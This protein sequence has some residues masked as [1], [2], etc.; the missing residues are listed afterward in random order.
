MT[1][2]CWVDMVGVINLRSRPDR[3]REMQG[4][5]D[6]I[7]LGN[8]SRVLFIDGIVA[9]DPAPFR[10]VGERGV[11]LSHLSILR[12]AAAAE[13]SV[14]ILEDDADFTPAAMKWNPSSGWDIAYGGYSAT[15]P[16]FL[17]IS[18]I[19]GAHC[20]G[21]SIR[22]AGALVPYLERLLTIESPPPI[23]GAYVWFRREFP[24]FATVFAEPVIADQRPS[25][26]DIAGS[27]PFDRIVILRPLLGIARSI[28][29]ML[30][31]RR[32]A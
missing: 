9:D 5:L 18:D 14:L 4:E 15:D 6:R 27:G 25:R 31:R 24:E 29:R 17:A 10:L 19:V 1:P 13:K 28:K 11:F 2:L 7:G 3:R 21:F 30:I 20:M 22:A 8:D 12:K 16:E 23:D 32:R 26:S